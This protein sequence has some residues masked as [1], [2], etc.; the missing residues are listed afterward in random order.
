MYPES[1]EMFHVVCS[2]GFIGNV[3][4]EALGVSACM[5]AYSHLSFSEDQHLSAL[6]SNHYYLLREYVSGMDQVDVVMAIC[7]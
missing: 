3:T 7:D 6:C 2:N 4:G 1:R 5:Y